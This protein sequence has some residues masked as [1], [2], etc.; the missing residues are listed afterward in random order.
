M[1][2]NTRNE[3]L[4]CLARLEDATRPADRRRPL[5]GLSG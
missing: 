1:C 3:A 4:A 2:G 5:C